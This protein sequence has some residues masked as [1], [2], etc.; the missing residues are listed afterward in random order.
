[1]C[2][3][4]IPHHHPSLPPCAAFLVNHSTAYTVAFGISQLEYWAEKLFLFPEGVKGHAAI[5]VPAAAVML[6]GDGIR[7]AGMITAGKS[8]THLVAYSH[9][10]THR[11]VTW[12]VYRCV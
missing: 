8:F 4:I 2:M 12:G 9:T 5:A 3:I 7:K 1:M 6:L 11:L 10:S